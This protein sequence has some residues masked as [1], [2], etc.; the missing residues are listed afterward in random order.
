MRTDW[1]SG[2]WKPELIMYL[3]SPRYATGLVISERS[4][5]CVQDILDWSKLFNLAPG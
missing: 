3:S 1:V 5:L 2:I 4:P